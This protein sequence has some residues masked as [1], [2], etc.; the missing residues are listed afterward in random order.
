MPTNVDVPPL[1]ESVSEATLLRWLKNEGDSVVVGEPLAELETD[2]ANVDLP[3]TAA[4]V[5]RRAKDAGATVKVGE[6]IAR[7]E[8]GGGGNGAAVKTASAP[9]AK[10]AAAPASAP[11]PPAA[12]A[13]K[14]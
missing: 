2:K 9:A 5:L 8:E 1:G 7:I 6:V 10:P 12:S 14:P 4:G 3:S 11:T 13:A